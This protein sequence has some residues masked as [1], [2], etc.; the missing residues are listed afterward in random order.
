[1]KK[2][3]IMLLILLLVLSVLTALIFWILCRSAAQMEF[4][5]VQDKKEP[6][7]RCESCVRYDECQAVDEEC[8]VRRKRNG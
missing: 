5:L 1:M 6:E 3:K 8:P 2:A 7:D 4:R